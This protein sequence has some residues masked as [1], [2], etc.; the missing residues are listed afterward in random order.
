M[1]R[2][3]DLVHPVEPVP[4]TVA[5]FHLPGARALVDCGAAA[6]LPS[7]EA[8]LAAYG[9][10]IEDLDHLLL[11]HVHLD[12]AGGAGELAARNPRLQVWVHEI[13]VRHLVDP[14]RLIES[15]RSVYGDDFEAIWGRIL[16][17]AA[18]RVH[19][20]ATEQRL[21]LPGAPLAVPTPGHCRH[22]IA[23]LTEDGTLYAGDAAGG[24]W[25]GTPGY[26][27]P[28]APPP[29]PDADAWRLTIARLRALEPARL[30]ISHFGVVTDVPLHLD[31]L[32]A[33]LER[34]VSRLD[35]TVEAFVAATDDDRATLAAA[36]PTTFWRY[37][38][39]ADWS[40][41]GLSRW[42][43]RTA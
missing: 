23:Y 4:G 37:A 35:G 8:G 43:A 40:Y 38:S 31:A 29:D 10:A 2:V 26:V 7:L 6:N 41:A 20:I 19:S 33:G 21:D 3:L 22:Q 30:A 36:S 16:P 42:R 11:T 39:S 18:D 1:I 9:V 25:H 17:I 34:W 5:A 27:E 12:H 28:A 32:A 14:T 15:T 24:A 13:G